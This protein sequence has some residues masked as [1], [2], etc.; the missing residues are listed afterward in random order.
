M[1]DNDNANFL[2]LYFTLVCC[3]YDIMLCFISFIKSRYYILIF[4]G[5]ITLIT[6]IIFNP[7]CGTYMYT[8]LETATYLNRYKHTTTI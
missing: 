1:R 6:V 3:E 2:C 7:F 8:D 5:L 4:I